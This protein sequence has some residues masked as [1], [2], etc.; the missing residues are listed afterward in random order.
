VSLLDE[1]ETGKQKRDKLGALR[2]L[3]TLGSEA[4]IGFFLNG[5]P[6][7]WAFQ[8]LL[9]FRPLRIAETP[10]EAAA[11]R[12]LKAKSSAEA[13]QAATASSSAGLGLDDAP[14]LTTSATL[15]AIM[16]SRENPYDD[17][18]TGYFP[19]VSLY[20]GARARLKTR[21]DELSHFV[22]PTEMESALENAERAKSGLAAISQ[23][24]KTPRWWG[25]TQPLS[26]RYDEYWQEQW[27]LD[28]EEEERA[29][30]RAKLIQQ[31]QD[32]ADAE[33]EERERKA[34][35][36]GRKKTAATKIVKERR[37]HTPKEQTV[38]EPAADDSPSDFAAEVNGVDHQDSRMS[39]AGLMDQP[40]SLA[41]PAVAETPTSPVPSIVSGPVEMDQ[42]GSSPWQTA[43]PLPRPAALDSPA[44][45]FASRLPLSSS[46]EGSQ[47]DVYH[48]AGGYGNV[49]A[50]DGLVEVAL[51][52][53][54]GQGDEEAETRLAAGMI[55]ERA[56]QYEEE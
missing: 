30:V 19:A 38:E 41:D 40:T 48:N 33:E 36:K 9:D 54:G 5:Q 13:Q 24:E 52:G 4:R 37:S 39:L 34:M 7:G 10:A 20:G 22:N 46:G 55:A 14:L 21:P 17:G 51:A 27:K 25:Q 32:E 16:K 31:L 50:L 28:L 49:S 26:E 35:A 43:T 1:R 29:V 15:A 11:N 23:E 12:K 6:M 2:T 42:D 44:H 3:P 53:G 18:S 47:I 45:S 56:R 8:D